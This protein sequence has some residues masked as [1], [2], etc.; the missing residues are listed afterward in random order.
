MHTHVQKHTH[1]RAHVDTRKR[2][3]KLA[4]RMLTSV[5]TGT[6]VMTRLSPALGARSPAEGLRV[7]TC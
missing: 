6:T 2:A 3:S 4:P 1:A 5:Q 7:F